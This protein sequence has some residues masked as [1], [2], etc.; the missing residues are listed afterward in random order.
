MS[1]EEMMELY[2][3][4]EMTKVY[5]LL[6]RGETS[7]HINVVNVDIVPDDIH[8]CEEAFIYELEDCEKDMLLGN[9]C[10]RIRRLEG[11]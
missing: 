10:E 8:E 11:V 5:R 2:T 6:N 9:L 3:D 4:G 7:G 1:D